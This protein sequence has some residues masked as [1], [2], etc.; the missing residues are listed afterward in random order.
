[1]LP[2]KILKSL[3]SETPFLV[4]WEDKFCPK[5]SLNQLSFLCLFL[6][7]WLRLEVVNFILYKLCGFWN[8]SGY[9]FQL[10]ILCVV[11]WYEYHKNS[12]ENFRT[13][14][15]LLSKSIP[16][17]YWSG[18]GIFGQNRKDPDE[19]RMI[20]ES[21]QTY[22]FLWPHL[23]LTRLNEFRFFLTYFLRTSFKFSSMQLKLVN[24]QRKNTPEL[25]NDGI[26]CELI[27][28]ALRRYGSC[29]N[30]LGIARGQSHLDFM[31]F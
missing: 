19:I 23:C 27:V 8:C 2:Q 4:F 3:C 29:V 13:T 21:S 10:S 28:C 14:F 30:P 22:Y 12:F 31:L 5:C 16:N 15:F 20:K 25:M 6:L 11:S 18:F 24:V 9:H 17:A 1:M 7:A 26:W